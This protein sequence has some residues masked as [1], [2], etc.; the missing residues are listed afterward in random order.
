MTKANQKRMTIK[1]R[2]KADELIPPKKK[3]YDLLNVIQAKQIVSDV[4]V[5]GENTFGQIGFDPDTVTEVVRPRI[6]PLNLSVVDIAAGAM[7]NV[8]LTNEGEVYT[9]GINDEHQLGRN[10]NDDEAETLYLPAKVDIREKVVQITAGEMHTAVLT[11]TGKVFAW[12]TFRDNCGQ[13]GLTP[14]GIQAFPHHILPD[15]KI[16]KIS[17]GN[18]HIIFLSDEGKVFTCGAADQ[19]QLG[20]VASQ[21]ADRGG[22]HGIDY[23]LMPA[24]VR[25][26]KAVYD[27]I[28][29][30]RFSSFMKERDSGVIYGCGLNQYK[31]TCCKSNLTQCFIPLNTMRGKKWEQ[32]SSGEHHTIALDEDGHLHSFGRGDHGR[33]GLGNS[34]DQFEPILNPTLQFEKCITISAGD[35]SSFAVTEQGL[36]Y[37]WGEGTTFQ[38]GLG[39]DNTEVSIPTNVVGKDINNY[40]ITSVSAG[41]NHIIMLGTNKEN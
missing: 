5:C 28:W 20:R 11:E 15:K 8:I 23:I 26:N 14:A 22:R 38:L 24:E 33:L 19:G 31:Q 30:G 27:D 4:L 10:T 35:R 18:N 39:R 12:G 9:F 41:G 32:I 29:A 16:V 34:E 1:K 36:L 3:K 40:R 21:F 2:S 17:S 13:I 25:K 7:H 6:L 37:S